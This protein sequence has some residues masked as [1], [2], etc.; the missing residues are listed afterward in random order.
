[1]NGKKTKI[2]VRLFEADLN[3]LRA[4]FPA[5]YNYIVRELVHEFCANHYKT[6]VGGKYNVENISIDDS[7]DTML[8]DS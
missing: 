7:D 6:T 3:Y 4:N 1:M 8:N 2:N 5:N